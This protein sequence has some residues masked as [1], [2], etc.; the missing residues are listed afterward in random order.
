MTLRVPLGIAL[1]IV[2]FW[3]HPCHADCPFPHPASARNF[4]ATLGQAFYPCSAE[5]DFSCCHTANATTEGGLP[6]CKPAES[7]REAAGSPTAAWVWGP[8]SSGSVSIQAKNSDLAISVKLRDIRDGNGLVTGM[9][10]VLFLMRV[11]L[12]DA[13]T[14]SMSVI[15][16]PLGWALPVENGQG[17]LRTTLGARVPADPYLAD[18]IGSCRSFEILTVLVK[19]PSFSGFASTGFFLP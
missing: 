16:L 7:F 12:F 5:E 19:D 11:T 3:A 18:L 4:R 8:K 13:S 6:S 9:G 15:D 10:H 14:G 1:A 2:I 17:N